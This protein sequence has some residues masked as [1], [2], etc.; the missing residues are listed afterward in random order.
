MI[1][2]EKYIQNYNIKI[3]PIQVKIINAE[4]TRNTETIS[5]MV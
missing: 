2:L 4:L 5:N 1:C 3:M